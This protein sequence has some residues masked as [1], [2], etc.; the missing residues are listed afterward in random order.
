M[1]FESKYS[2]DIIKYL[3]KKI[4]TNNENIVPFQSNNFFMKLTNSIK[5]IYS[6][7][8]VEADL[9]KIKCKNKLFDK[10]N[11]LLKIII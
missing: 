8:N 1:I 4:I 2:D 9:K 6:K 10:N 11:D 7:T 3:N 5:D